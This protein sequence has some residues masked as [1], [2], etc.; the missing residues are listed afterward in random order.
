MAFT[1]N[2]KFT[3]A[4]VMK[5]AFYDLADTNRETK[6]FTLD[7]L[8]I[9]NITQEGPTK[10]SMGG[11][12]GETV[13]KYGKTMRLEMEDVITKLDAL[14]YLMGATLSSPSTATVSQAFV[15]TGAD[16]DLTLAATP[17][18][19]PIVVLNYAG[20]TTSLTLTDE[21]TISGNVIS[22]DVSEFAGG[23]EPSAG[24]VFKVTYIKATGGTVQITDQFSPGYQVV[25]ETFVIDAATGQKR[26]VN[27]IIHKFYPDSIFN[28]TM[29]VE[30]EFSVLAIAGDIK[31]NACGVFYEFYE[32]SAPAGC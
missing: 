14:T 17:T 20:T 6:L 26:W 23:A 5:P 22:I 11:I 8:R 24:D 9:S 31:P 16:Q 4:T 30:G 2:D 29:E 1:V 3:F 21:F 18:T 19:T 13:I 28:Q 27:I 25:G 32:G 7:S 12:F 10:T 15:A